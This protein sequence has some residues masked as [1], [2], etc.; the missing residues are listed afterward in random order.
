[1]HPQ[2]PLT[3]SISDFFKSRRVPA[4]TVD[5]VSE[6]ALWGLRRTLLDAAY[7]LRLARPTVR[8]YELALAARATVGRSRV[9]PSD[10]LPLPPARLRA[11]VG[12]SHADPAVFLRSGEEHAALIAELVAED[13]TSLEDLDDILDFG[14]GCGRVLRH[15]SQLSNVRV[16]GSDITPTMVEWCSQNLP[17]ADVKVNDVEPP[18][19]FADDSFDLVYAFSVFTHLPE[20]LQH[21]WMNEF[22]RVLRPKGY[23]L[24]STLGEHY[25]T[26]QRLTEQE[27]ERFRDGQLVV[28]YE[29]APGTS[30][31]SAYAPPRYVHERLGDRF[32]LLGFHPAADE[33]R[34]DL[35][36]FRKPA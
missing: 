5:N 29:R 21:E 31:C 15:W 7:K 20:S 24:I 11:Q 34:H 36:L 33:G 16:H 1:M 19:P 22:T 4:V 26:L 8:A 12:P 18:L 17:F 14:C 2:T 35:H 9:T 23:L 10:D 6:P 30:L 28:L 3:T 13:G 32:E 25:V 27:E